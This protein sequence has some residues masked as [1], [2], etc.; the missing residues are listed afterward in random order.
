[1]DDECVGFVFSGFQ[2]NLTSQIPS[3]TSISVDEPLPEFSEAVLVRLC[4]CAASRFQSQPV[5][6][7]LQSPITIIGDIHGSIHDLL[8]ILR[9]AGPEANYLF[10]GDYVD[11]GQYSLECITLLFALTC[12]YPET[13][14]LI[15]GNHETTEISSQ[16]G[17][18]TEILHS[19]SESLFTAFCH[20][21]G[22]LPLAA[23]VNSTLFC[24]H[25]GIGP[26]LE[27]IEQI[28]A[29]PRPIS[30]SRDHP[31]LH[32]ILWA[33]PNP[34][35]L[36]FGSSARGSCPTFGVA[37]ASDFLER[38]HCSLIVRAH[39]CVEA[40]VAWTMSMPVI[41]VFSASWYEPLKPNESGILQVDEGGRLRKY[42]FPAMERFPR[43]A[44][45]FYSMKHSIID[46]GRGTKLTRI[47]ASKSD[48]SVMAR[49]RQS[50]S[51]QFSGKSRLLP[52]KLSKKSR[53]NQFQVHSSFADVPSEI[54]EICED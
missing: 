17:F 13:C 42:V 23:I 33:D 24:V 31:L 22:W 28:S 32:D 54:S 48:A 16:Y 50:R 36:R 20:A 2:A 41:T 40:G 45:T 5:V 34:D 47:S 12:R 3:N 38:N 10:L 53:S 44:A 49:S 29:I 18:R 37:A 7:P 51:G 9:V 15:R 39:Q 46:G 11:R 26:G 1:M 14:H 4:D 35:I 25:G 8:R 43:A 6:L 27:T 21:F 52:L 19:Y 30:S